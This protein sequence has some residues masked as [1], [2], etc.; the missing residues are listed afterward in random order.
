MYASF[1]AWNERRDQIEALVAESV[2]RENDVDLEVKQLA[3]K[4]REITALEER[5]T[6]LR[7]ERYDRSLNPSGSNATI[8]GRVDDTRKVSLLV[9]NL[10]QAAE[11]YAVFSLSGPIPQEKRFSGRWEHTHST[12]TVIAKGETRCLIL[13]NMMHRNNFQQWQIFA[14][15]E[16]GP[17]Y[18]QATQSS[19]ATSTP[20]AK[21]SDIVISGE[22]VAVPDLVNGIQPFKVVL[23]AF[24]AE[25]VDGGQR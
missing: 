1:L 12:K 19:C 22:L 16:T 13:A 9:T 2:K 17:L 15:G 3:L 8:T 11:F 24:D 7:R 4:E 25:Y 5:N 18:I 21:A 6:E 14:I 23:H 10:G 20:I